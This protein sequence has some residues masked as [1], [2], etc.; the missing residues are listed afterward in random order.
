MDLFTQHD[1]IAPRSPPSVYSSVMYIIIL[2][3]YVYSMMLK[4]RWSSLKGLNQSYYMT[5]QSHSWA[6]VQRKPYSEKMLAPLYSQYTIYNSQYVEE[7]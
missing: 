1:I 3:L 4:I 2:E 7:T 5:Q 6:Y